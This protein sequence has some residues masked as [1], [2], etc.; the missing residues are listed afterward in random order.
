MNAI[1]TRR[2][3][4]DPFALFDSVLDDFFAR[5]GAVSAPLAREGQSLVAKARIEVVEKPEAYEVRADLPGVSKDDIEV[6][7]HEATV[8]IR[9]T[10]KSANEQKDS[11]K[12][13]FSERSYES[14]A[15]TFELPQAVDSAAAQAKF[16]NGVLTLTLP[17]VNAPQVKRVSV[18]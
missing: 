11:E 5:P 17:R 4:R 9:A 12:I 2:N 15:R 18:Q 16:E 13:L 14:Y 8:S 1:I 10:R 6:D 7:V 3:V